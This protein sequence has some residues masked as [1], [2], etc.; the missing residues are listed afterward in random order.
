MHF[1]CL[2]ITPP[3]GT[4]LYVRAK[5]GRDNKLGR[6]KEKRRSFMFPFLPS[7]P[8]TVH[9]T[10]STAETEETTIELATS[11]ET[12]IGSLLCGGEC[13]VMVVEVDPCH[14]IHGVFDD[15]A[16]PKTT[17]RSPVQSLT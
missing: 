14:D 4:L 5:Y 15:T 6:V 12:A 2:S 8:L 3:A 7:T 10:T 13:E 1:I 16:T 17:P 9:V 11:A